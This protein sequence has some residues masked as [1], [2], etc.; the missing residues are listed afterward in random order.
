MIAKSLL[1]CKQT[2][3]NYGYFH[4]A[5]VSG[6]ST[7]L[8]SLRRISPSS[9][10]DQGL[11]GPLS[12]WF[13]SRLLCYDFNYRFSGLIEDWSCC[14]CRRGYCWRPNA[15]VANSAN[16]TSAEKIKSPL[17]GF[18]Y[19]FFLVVVA[20]FFFGV[21]FFFAGAFFFL[22]ARSFSICFQY[23]LSSLVKS[24]TSSL[25]MSIFFMYLLAT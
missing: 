23:F 5:S 25:A 19:F 17:R 9:W 21:A 2:Q 14:G 8:K 7:D 20:F 16:A 10:L 1:E 15:G 6:F 24:S 18:S 3:L 12:I 13:W 22:G 11:C 4:L